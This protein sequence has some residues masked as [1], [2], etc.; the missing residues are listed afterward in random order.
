MVRLGWRWGDQR[1]GCGP[2]Y[3]SEV[4]VLNQREGDRQRRD[5]QDSGSV[6]GVS[7]QL[8][9]LDLMREEKRVTRLSAAGFVGS[10]RLDTPFFK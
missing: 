7:G 4:A 1:G 2:G 3:V 10:E 8:E 9:Q 6:L 5:V